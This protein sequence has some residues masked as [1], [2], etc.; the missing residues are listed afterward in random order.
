[1]SLLIASLLVFLLW[2]SLR[3]AWWKRT[4][5]YRY[6]RILMYHMIS[7]LQPQ[8]KFKGLRVAPEMFERQVK[9]LHDKGWRFVTMSELAERNWQGEKLAALTFDDGYEDNYHHAFPVMK[10]YRA[11]G[12][13]Y[14]VTDRHE[15]DWSVAKKAHHDSG[16]LAAE[17]KLTDAQVQEMVDSGLFEIGGHTVTHCNLATTELQDKR[18]EV[19]QC[20]EQLEKTF[21]TSVGS[22]AYPFG[23]YGQ[24]DVVLVKEAGYV[25]AVTTE[26]GIDAAA[27]PLRLK[28]IKV[29]GKDGFFAFKVRIKKGLRGVI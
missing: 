14:L 11:C 5:D 10:K 17:E 24:Q 9:W 26:E 21:S 18:R 7:E 22:F 16:E 2:F 23:I 29:S 28:R 4:V 13:L 1:M 25:S 15:R 27:D 8:H 6:P 20:K 19:R 3:Y 12:T